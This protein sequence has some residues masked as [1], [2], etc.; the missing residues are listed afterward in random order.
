V[1]L[2]V[3]SDRQQ[4]HEHILDQQRMSTSG[5]LSTKDTFD[6][7]KT[8]MAMAAADEAS[9]RQRPHEVRIDQHVDEQRLL[10][11][12]L[13]ASRYVMVAT[14]LERRTCDQQVAGSTPC[15]GGKWRRQV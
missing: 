11:L 1:N 7:Y 10:D 6:L 5:R 9:G 8:F 3:T 13:T 12:Q 2:S 14:Q 15:R 4:L